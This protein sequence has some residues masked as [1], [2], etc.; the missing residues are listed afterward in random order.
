MFYSKEFTIS[1]EVLK[2]KASQLP[3][4]KWEE[5]MI[6]SRN[7]Q[8]PFIFLEFALKI[9]G[10]SEPIPVRCRLVVVDEHY[11]VADNYQILS[12][13]ERFG[14]K[15]EENLLESLEAFLVSCEIPN[16]STDQTLY[17][18]YHQLNH[19]SSL[20]DGTQ[21][22]KY[23][24]WNANYAYYKS[25]TK[26][27]EISVLDY[28]PLVHLNRKQRLF[29]NEFEINEEI[30]YYNNALYSTLAKESINDYF[31]KDDL[32][33]ERS[34]CNNQIEFNV[35][36]NIR[37]SYLRFKEISQ[38]VRRLYQYSLS[39]PLRIFP[40]T[41]EKLAEGFVN[42]LESLPLTW[43]E[44]T[45]INGIDFETNRLTQISPSTY[46]LI[47]LAQRLKED[48]FSALKVGDYICL[49]PHSPNAKNAKFGWIIGIEDEEKGIYSI[50]HEDHYQYHPKSTCHHS[51][52]KKVDFPKQ[53][54][55]NELVYVKRRGI[56][57]LRQTGYRYSQVELFEMKGNRE[58]MIYQIESY[59]KGYDNED[60]SLITLDGASE[61]W[62]RLIHSDNPL[63]TL[64]ELVKSDSTWGFVNQWLTY[65]EFFTT[66]TIYPDEFSLLFML[67]QLINH[68]SDT[69]LMFDL[70]LHS[71]V[72]AYG[73]LQSN[74]PT[75]V[76]E[77]IKWFFGYLTTTSV[78]KDYFKPCF[79][80]E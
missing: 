59:T 74:S 2:L 3:Q 10:V 5:K 16:P 70:I 79:P 47:V 75:S 56:G 61:T 11:I 15:K 51:E 13:P 4:F 19:E 14:S 42:T 71:S 76:I 65:C 35:P 23:C 66:P 45:V 58:K 67:I 30:G 50:K 41:K 36:K 28:Y 44:F 6:E 39:E 43:K 1:K 60:I 33:Q 27:Q 78:W 7:E 62:E 57:I 54:A 49:T 48:T 12:R 18:F 72:P 22:S 26:V 68:S 37:G 40:K 63:S 73:K 29:G 21:K 52:L 55:T 34:I 17:L 20:E 53:I 80:N 38:V 25:F 64:S 46:T 8:L 77:K 9:K 69:S 32:I 31:W 24:F